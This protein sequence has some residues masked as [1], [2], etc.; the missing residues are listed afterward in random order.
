M[1]KLFGLALLLSLSLCVSAQ[2]LPNDTTVVMKNGKSKLYI[3]KNWAYQINVLGNY[4][5]YDNKTEKWL[6]NHSGNVFGFEVERKG[7]FAMIDARMFSTVRPGVELL[8][9]DKIVPFDAKINPIRTDIAVGYKLDLLTFLTL[10]SHIG[11]MKSSFRVI[12][13]D[14]LG[15]TYDIPGKSGLTIGSGLNLYLGA[16]YMYFV[17]FLKYNFNL[18]N[19]SQINSNLGDHFHSIELGGSFK[20]WSRRIK[21]DDRFIDPN[22]MY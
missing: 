6:G 17:L 5:M 4:T 16:R 21:N 14:E 18:S 3:R 2:M 10:N 20:F 12:N 19:Y 13:E 22:R 9:N 15:E 11:W 1:K 8:I 7:I